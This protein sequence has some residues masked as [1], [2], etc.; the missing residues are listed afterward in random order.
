MARGVGPGN[1]LPPRYRGK[2]QRGLSSMIVIGPSL[3]DATRMSAPKTPRSTRAPR[4]VSSAQT[5]SYQ[6]SD[7][8]PGA[9]ACQVGRRPL[10]AS[11]YRVNWLTTRTG[12]ETSDA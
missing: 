6:G 3:T 7:T 1:D 10:R 5:A 11:P 2:P 9:A 8:G 4:A 12:A